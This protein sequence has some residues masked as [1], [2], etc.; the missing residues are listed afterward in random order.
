MKILIVDDIEVNLDLLEARLEG[1]GYE[2]ASAMNGVEA[3]EIL[4]TDSI[5]IIISDILM[6]EMDGFQFCRE[7][8]SDETLRK[9]PF[10]FYTAT[11][12]DKKDEEFALSLGAEKFIVKPMESKPF[13]EAV[14]EIL[15]N[16]K[17]GLLTPSEIPEEEEA[18]YLKEYNERLINKLED[19]M[20]GLE[21]EITERK[22]AEEALKKA[23][24]D[25]E[26][27][28]AERTEELRIAKEAAETANQAKSDF[29]ANMSHELRT[30][31]NAVLG[32]SQLM[33]NDPS[34]TE[35]QRGNLQ[36]I[37][38]SGEHLLTLIK[39]V[40]D[41]SKI[42]AGR[43][44]LEPEDLD[45]GG[46]IRDIIDMMSN[47]AEAKGL[48]LILDQSSDFP[49]Y[50]HA[51]PSKLRQILINLLSNAVKFTDTGGVTLHLDA[52]PAEDDGELILRGEV[53]DTG[54]GIVPDDIK[55][56]FTPFEQLAESATQKGTGLGLAIT[57]QFIEMMGG[58]I[59]AESEPGQGSVF[60]FTLQIQRAQGTVTAKVDTETRRIIGLEPDQP[61]YRIL[62][63][64]DH[65]DSRV[66]LEKLLEQAGF[67][68]QIAENGKEAIEAFQDWQPHFIWMD[69]RMPV[70]DGLE[71]TRRIKAMTGG[72][73]TVIVALTASV[74]KEQKNEVLEAGS[75]DFVRKPF[76]E[77]EIFEVMARHLGVR[78]VF[79]GAAKPSELPDGKPEKR[80]PM[81]VIEEIIR[82]VEWGDYAGL[83]RILDRLADEDADYGGFCSRI[84]G[85]ASN[86]DDEA[87][88]EYIRAEGRGTKDDGRED[89]G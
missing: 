52:M 78:Y 70:M 49:R 86:Y 43:S 24:D 57:R 81:E 18:V 76:R 31:L 2:V 87:I 14:E 35:T 62:I 63:V 39:D 67:T 64:E 58:E 89:E 21:K 1:S 8:K 34:T 51:D 85:Y 55:R 40:L 88:L 33:R 54:S 53:E 66:L 5:D 73:E 11:Y 71:A 74:F 30:P 20:I 77:A 23:H 45:L 22:L 46:M 59:T 50:V 80:P 47:H 36:I 15:K 60:R 10:V 28:I 7:C 13:M 65:Q 17:K 83:E 19:K 12:I 69:R 29:L 6:P 9:I 4:K 26:R 27:K 61:E 75:D 25:L 84:K 44:T 72:K 48:Q 41:M 56:I 16:H 42:E 82:I 3:L 37:N 79:E 38:R 32:F 68:V